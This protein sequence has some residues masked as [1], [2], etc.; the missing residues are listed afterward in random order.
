M[1]KVYMMPLAEVVKTQAEEMICQSIN[2]NG[3]ETP[4]NEEEMDILGKD[5][6]EDLW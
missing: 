3:A 4:F 2:I 1:K 6:L 5:G